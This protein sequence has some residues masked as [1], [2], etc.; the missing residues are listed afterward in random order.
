[1][2]DGWTNAF[3]PDD[4]VVAEP[5]WNECLKTGDEYLTE[6]RCMSAAGEW[7][8][9]LGRASAMRDDHGNIVKW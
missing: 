7:R 9:M 3:H 1:M 4:L 2:G 6:Y 5:K 8:W